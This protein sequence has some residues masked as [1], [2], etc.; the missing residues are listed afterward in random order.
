MRRE[1][2][3]DAGA[4]EGAAQADVVADAEATLECLPMD[5]AARTDARS[6]RASLATHAAHDRPAVHNNKRAAADE[7]SSLAPPRLLEKALL[8]AGLPWRDALAA[9]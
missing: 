2:E 6:Q 7:P 3:P 9:A 5:G 1:Q 8:G 4:A